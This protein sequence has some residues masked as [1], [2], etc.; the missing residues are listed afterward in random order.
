M[1]D[2][3]ARFIEFK[4]HYSSRRVE[5]SLTFQ[6]FAIDAKKAILLV[7]LAGNFETGDQR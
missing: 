3:P 2:V 6:H 1:S 4:Q 7:A 5:M